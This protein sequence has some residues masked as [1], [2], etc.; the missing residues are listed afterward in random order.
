MVPSSHVSFIADLVS[1][2]PLLPHLPYSSLRHTVPLLSPDIPHLSHCQPSAGSL[3]LTD[4]G[5]SVLSSLGLRV[6]QAELYS[7]LQQP[8]L[9]D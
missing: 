9:G 4:A 8:Q 6:W 1:L 2:A 7:F 3:P 5:P